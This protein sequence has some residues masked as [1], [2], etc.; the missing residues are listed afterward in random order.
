MGTL[1]QR[2]RR[3]AGKFNLD[4]HPVGDFNPPFDAV[5]AP[6][7]GRRE[8]AFGRRDRGLGP[9]DAVGQT[10]LPLDFAPGRGRLPQAHQNV[11][12]MI[13]RMGAPGVAA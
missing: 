8:R 7:P 1:A 10:G 3:D 11:H 12:Q 4:N 13:R 5:A 2:P 6:A 9:F